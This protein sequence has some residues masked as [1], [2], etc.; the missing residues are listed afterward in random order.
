MNIPIFYFEIKIII[1]WILIPVKTFTQVQL[2][3]QT[4]FADSLN[5]F[6]LRVIDETTN[7]LL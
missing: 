3:G 1:E 5:M 2:F 7:H 6:G 4:F